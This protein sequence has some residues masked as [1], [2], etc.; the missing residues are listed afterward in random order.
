MPGSLIPYSALTLRTKSTF[1][2]K[3]PLE[4]SSAFSM[5]PFLQFWRHLYTEWAIN[6]KSNELER[7]VRGLSH[8]L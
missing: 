6:N 1:D 4:E 3:V 8:I 7:N 2:M 5:L